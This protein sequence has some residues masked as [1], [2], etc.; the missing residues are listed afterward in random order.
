MRQIEDRGSEIV[1]QNIR[2]AYNEGIESVI[3]IRCMEHRN[4][5]AMN[6]S[7]GDGECAVCAVK[8]REESIILR[9]NAVLS[10][11]VHGIDKLNDV[12]QPFIDALEKIA[13]M[14]PGALARHD[15]EVI[16][17]WES[18]RLTA[19]FI[20]K[21]EHPVLQ[22]ILKERAAQDEEW[23]GPG[24]DNEHSRFDWVKYIREHGGR[25]V[26]GLAKDDFRKQM[27]RVAALAV[28]AVQAYDRKGRCFTP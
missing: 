17:D 18:R 19:S 5:S 14:G 25:S 7:E 10:E 9:C 21:P 23:G 15:R 13:E 1:D 4:I 24:H 12:P 27:I 22:E 2:A 28:A 20:I 6:K 11:M 16:L 8:E 3:Y 26:R